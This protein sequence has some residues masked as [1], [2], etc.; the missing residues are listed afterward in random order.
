MRKR[1]E[2]R[3]GVSSLD[4][5]EMADAFKTVQV[6]IGNASDFD[7]VK[8]DA[9]LNVNISRAG[10]KIGRAEIACRPIEPDSQLG[11]AFGVRELDGNV[12]TINCVLK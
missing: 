11:S 6:Y 7:I 12:V 9:A 4:L 1:K 2:I 3:L 5:N 10:V 8:S